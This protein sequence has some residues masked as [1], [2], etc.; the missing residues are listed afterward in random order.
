MSF[1]S[2]HI[3]QN[4]RRGFTLIELLVVIA[5]I[6]LL[7]SILLPSL[8]KAK[9][10]AMRTVC[11]VN[12]RQIHT[13][14]QMYLGDNNERYPPGWFTCDEGTAYWIWSFFLSG[15][16]GGPE[17]LPLRKS[18]D[19]PAATVFF[20]PTY[21]TKTTKVWTTYAV[22][23]HRFSRVHIV[24][25]GDPWV[26]YRPYIQPHPIT[27]ETI[28]RVGNPA[29][30]V[31]LYCSSASGVMMCYPGSGEFGPCWNYLV[32]VHE[33]AYPILWF[34]GHVSIEDPWIMTLDA[35]DNDYW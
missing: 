19:D 17:Y 8:Q 23:G 28:R 15:Y 34:D 16:M 32:D 24:N 13:G 31:M 14:F 5:I 35:Y 29:S 18:F 9:V 12:Q 4:I 22:N 21:S 26:E 27:V 1:S 20:C 33:E 11:T 6:S 10:L 2:R 30:T 25:R 7:V 3:A